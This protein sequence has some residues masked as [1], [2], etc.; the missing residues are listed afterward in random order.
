MPPPSSPPPRQVKKSPTDSLKVADAIAT[1]KDDDD[2]NSHL[3]PGAR[4]TMGPLVL[5]TIL[6]MQCMFQALILTMLGREVILAFGVA[7]GVPVLVLMWLPTTLMSLFV[8]PH[9]IK[10]LALARAVVE[11]NHD[12]LDKME[13]VRSPHPSPCQCTRRGPMQRTPRPNATPHAHVDRA[14]SRDHHDHHDLPSQEFEQEGDYSA[15]SQALELM[16]GAQLTDEE[17]KDAE[18]VRC[19]VHDLNKLGEMKWRYRVVEEGQSP[20]EEALKVLD[21]AKALMDKH[22]AL[23]PLPTSHLLQPPHQPHAS[24]PDHVS[25]MHQAHV[26]GERTAHDALAEWRKEVTMPPPSP[27]GTW[28]SG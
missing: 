25:R 21:E 10:N 8:T 18:L 9:V 17:A 6:L 7:K 24:V 3:E 14:P 16:S 20:R 12:V 22:Q 19:K 2:A 27:G 15:A 13:K 11:A 5:Q 4:V 26:L 23:P 1:L 28:P